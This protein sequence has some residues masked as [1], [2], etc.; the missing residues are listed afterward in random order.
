MSNVQK[1]IAAVVGVI[2]VGF[3]LVG[4]SGQD[5]ED[6]MNEAFL[7]NAAMLYKI[8]NTQCP[9][10]LKKHIG[11]NVI[12]P[13]ESESDKKTF[14]KLTWV[15]KSGDPFKKASCLIVENQNSIKELIVDGKTVLKDGIEVASD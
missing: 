2:V 14:V 5:A 3:L 11:A 4:T 7:R 1:L 15:N 8:A 6:K 12:A 13:T 10:A 9:K